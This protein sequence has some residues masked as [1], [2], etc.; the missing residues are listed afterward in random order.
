[1]GSSGPAFG[2]PR[3][4]PATLVARPE[5]EAER[6]AETRQNDPA[7]PR[8]RLVDHVIGEPG[9]KR[10]ERRQARA[11]EQRPE[12][13]EAR[14]VDGPGEQRLDRVAGRRRD[15]RQHQKEAQ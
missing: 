13:V 5:R 11:A 3:S 14:H 7:G 8:Q 9:R 12:L 10:T 4:P 2:A 1:M 6:E 15:R